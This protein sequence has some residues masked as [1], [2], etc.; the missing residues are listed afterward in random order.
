MAALGL[1]RYV[2]L[3]HSVGA[4]MALHIAAAHP[5]QCQAVLSLSAQAYVQPRTLEGIREAQRFF[6][7]PQQ[8]ARLAKWHGPR[9]DWVFRAWTDVWLHPDFADWSLDPVLPQVACPVLAIHGRN[10][11]YGSP[12]FARRIAAGVANGQVLLLDCAH[13]PHRQQADQVLA[14][15][16][17]FLRCPA[18]AHPLD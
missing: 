11:E 2:L 6:A 14:A 12:E 9:L 4:V 15:A 18:L 1:Q 8:W 16:R 3:G 7:D 10:D 17:D 13:H 5:L